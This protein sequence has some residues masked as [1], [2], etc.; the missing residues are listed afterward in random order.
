MTPRQKIELR[1]SE[2]RKA[3]NDMLAVEPE[4]RGETFEADMAK[5]VGELRSLETELQ[6]AIVAE[7]PVQETR[8]DDTPE[9]REMRELRERVDFGDYVQAALSLRSVDGAAR[10]LNAALGIAENKFPL[11]LLALEK[12][13]KRDGDAEGNQASWLDRV[14]D[15]TAADRLGITM[16]PVAPGVAAFPVLTAGGSP[17]QRGREEA[18]AESTYTVAVTEIKP[19]RAAIHGLY[20]VEDDARLPGL[21]DAI[22]RDMQSAMAEGIDRKVFLGDS[23]ANENVADIVGLTTAGIAETTL[24]QSNKVKAD[25]TLKA[26]VAY[27][28]GA[29]AQSIGHVRVVVSEGTAQLW[30]GTIHNSA[31]DN[32]T[33]AQF[34]MDSG[35]SWGVRGGIDTNTAAGDFG[36]FVGLARGIEGAARVAVWNAGELIRDP[37]S[38]ASKGEVQLTLNYLWGFAIP[39]TANYKRLKF[40]A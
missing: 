8:N 14:M 12:R 21:A 36:A 11:E 15:G 1:Q 35:L 39:R 38:G 17:A 10:E 4:K 3:I 33:I 27:L 31:V 7:P 6:A 19:S 18:V 26:F 34:L 37:Y 23:G 20:S 32:Q 24:T 30:Y 22:M 2:L 29:H 28:D 40:T 25:E 16:T 9:G 5:T 13:A